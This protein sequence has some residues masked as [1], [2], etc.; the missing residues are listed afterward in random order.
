MSLFAELRRRNVIRV[1]GLYIVTAWLLV[2]VAGTL[3]PIFHTPGWVLQALVVLLALGFVPALI[4]SWV[5][6]LTPAGLKRDGEVARGTGDTSAMARRLD[7]L[8]LVGVGV[9]LAV[10]AADRFWPRAEEERGPESISGTEA[11][12]A[13]ESGRPE[14]DSGPLSSSPVPA[15]DGKSIAVLPFVNMTAEA[16]NEFFADGLSEEILNALANIE[17]LQVTGRTSSFQFKGRNEDLR[18]VGEQL[19]VANV[20][21]GSVR[22]S[23]DRVRVTAQLVRAAD[24]FH[25]WSQTYDRAV[26]DT[27]AVQL[28]IATNVSAALD[29]VLDDAQQERMARTGVRDVDAFIAYQK[30]LALLHQAH[31]D[32][33]DIALLESAYQEFAR[34]IATEPRMALAYYVRT[35]YYAHMLAQDSRTPEEHARLHALYQADLA[36]AARL[37]TAPGQRALIELDSILIS[38]DWRALAGQVE[39]VL[40]ARTCGEVVWADVVSGFVGPTRFLGW[41]E[42][43]RECDPLNAGDLSMTAM[44]AVLAGRPEQALE[45]GEFARQHGLAQNFGGS[46]V[47]ALLLLNRPDDARRSAAAVDPWLRDFKALQIASFLGDR[48]AARSARDR[49]LSTPKAATNVSADS[50][51]AAHAIAGD[52]AAANRVAA[53][54]DRNPIGPMMLAAAAAVCACGATFDLEHTPRFKARLAEAGWPWPPHDVMHYKLKDW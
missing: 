41:R 9:L 23:A 29:V 43:L 10:F 8:T 39:S 51:I 14:I 33:I 53:E 37:T 25:L 17:G 38:D 31:Y 15:K 34:A 2:Q 13:A 20:L 22:R 12:A 42:A 6:E 18:S 47:T 30:G 4:F 36:Q 26:T 16:D 54:L 45:L 19:G 46:D 1:A 44:A 50:R 7:M 52:R 35:D 24:G 11:P 3:L 32:Y 5:F 21:E 28:D 40:D 48:E 27:L 49:Y